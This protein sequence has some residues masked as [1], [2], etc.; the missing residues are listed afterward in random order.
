M[1]E[2]TDEH[3]TALLKVVWDQSI[4]GSRYLFGWPRQYQFTDFLAGPCYFI[5]LTLQPNRRRIVCSRDV[6][7]FSLLHKQS[8][9]IRNAHKL[10]VTLSQ[11]AVRIVL[12]QVLLRLVNI[13]ACLT[14]LIERNADQ[15]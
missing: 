3:A 9:L 11:H 12:R 5:E 10:S 15:G 8:V 7:Y 14:L 6:N 13:V 1:T 4:D 2:T